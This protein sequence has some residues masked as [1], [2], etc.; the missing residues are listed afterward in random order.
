M[1]SVNLAE[2]RFLNVSGSVD[3]GSL[4]QMNSPQVYLGRNSPPE[5]QSMRRPGSNISST[6]RPPLGSLTLGEKEYFDREPV[7]SRIYGSCKFIFLGKIH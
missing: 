5:V 6:V 1:F 2:F 3:Q 4:H 7:Q